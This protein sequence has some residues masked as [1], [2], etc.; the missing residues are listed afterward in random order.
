MISAVCIIS[1]AWQKSKSLKTFNLNDTTVYIFRLIF[2]H[3]WIISTA[4]DKLALPKVIADIWEH[5]DMVTLKSNG[6]GNTSSETPRQVVNKPIESSD[7]PN[8]LV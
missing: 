8:H 2:C 1:I 6:A 3:F 5:S 7:Y 4:Y